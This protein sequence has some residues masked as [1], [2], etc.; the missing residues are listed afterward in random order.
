MIQTANDSSTSSHT[1]RILVEEG[2]EGTDHTHEVT[3][4]HHNH[5][6]DSVLASR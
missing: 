4:A 2:E 3:T 6:A 1:E 5:A